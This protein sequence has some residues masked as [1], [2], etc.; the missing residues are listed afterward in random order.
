MRAWA[1]DRTERVSV[2]NRGVQGDANSVAPSVSW[3][4]R[5]VAFVSCSTNLVPGDRNGFCDTFVRDRR[6][7]RTERISRGLGGGE[8]NENSSG[9][10]TTISL[11]GRI[12]AFSSSASNLVPGDTNL[13]RDIFAYNRRTGRTERVNVSSGGA[14]ADRGSSFPRDVS[15]DGRF[16]LFGSEA[17]NLVDGDTNG[18]DDLFVRDRK[19]GETERVNVELLR[20]SG[21]RREFSGGLD[22]GRRALRCFR[23]SSEQSGGGCRK[24]FKCTSVT[25]G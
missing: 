14:Q 25:V 13:L 2:G 23:D 20:S 22:L 6:T 8:P 4:G 11:D 19:T 15:A 16:V 21:E 7:G 17:T 5:F 18:F 1:S 10:G 12:A 24:S 3:N 9:E